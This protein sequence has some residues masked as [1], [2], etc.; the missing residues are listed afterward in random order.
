[1]STKSMY[2]SQ[3]YAITYQ[4]N[5]VLYET[6]QLQNEKFYLPIIS[7]VKRQND[8]IIFYIFYQFLFLKT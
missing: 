1:M 6:F 4:K 2:G 5:K 7:D 8:V 3:E